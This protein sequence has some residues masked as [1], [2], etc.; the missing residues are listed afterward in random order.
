MSNSRSELVA[1]AKTISVAAARTEYAASL[2]TSR[3]LPANCGRNRLQKLGTVVRVART[4]VPRRARMAADALTECK[5]II[6]NNATPYSSWGQRLAKL[7]CLNA[8][9]PEKHCFISMYVL[10]P[11]AQARHR[12]ANNT[13][14]GGYLTIRVGS[15]SQPTPMPTRVWAELSRIAPAAIR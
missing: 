4:E 13:V 15:N 12:C 2:L 6:N 3:R 8:P 1:R 5:G 11:S 7:N 9:I 10:M 14:S